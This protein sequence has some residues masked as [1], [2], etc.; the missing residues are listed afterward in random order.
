MQELVLQASMV[1]K[2]YVSTLTNTGNTHRATVLFSL[3][4]EA[5][6]T[7]VTMQRIARLVMGKLVFS[8]PPQFHTEG[9]ENAPNLTLRIAVTSYRCD[10]LHVFP[11][12]GRLVRCTHLCSE[13]PHGQSIA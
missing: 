6:G 13:S 4:E 9:A 10:T 12:T 8:Q 1:H 5:I 3:A 2:G 7:A 11:T